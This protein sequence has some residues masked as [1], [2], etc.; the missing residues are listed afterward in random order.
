MAVLGVGM[1]QTELM[2]VDNSGIEGPDRADK[3]NGR[4]DSKS[5]MRKAYS[6]RVFLTLSIHCTPERRS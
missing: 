6:R 3:V 5:S 1:E 2:I 4:A